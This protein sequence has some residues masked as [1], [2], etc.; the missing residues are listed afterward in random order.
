MPRKPRLTLDEHIEMGRVPVGV[1]DELAHRAVQVD[2]V[3]PRSAPEGLPDKK[4]GAALRALDEAR[5]APE[6]L[7]SREY[8]EAAEATV[9]YPLP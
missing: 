5:S 4:V 1:R 8:P 9:Y 3:Y 7:L 6:T 2:K